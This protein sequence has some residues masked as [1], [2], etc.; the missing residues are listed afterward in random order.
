METLGVGEV[1]GLPSAGAT[2]N[3]KLEMDNYKV[4]L[5]ILVSF[6]YKE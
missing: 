3:V 4:Y 1:G 2:I 5:K 6:G